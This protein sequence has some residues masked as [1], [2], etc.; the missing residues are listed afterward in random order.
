MVT[1]EAEI[2]ALDFA[3][4]D[5]ALARARAAI[6]QAQ[7]LSLGDLNPAALLG[8]LGTAIEAVGEVRLDA[9]TVNELGGQALATL[10]TLVTLPDFAGLDDVVDG[11]ER[12]AEQL[13]VP[14][15]VFSGSGDGTAVLDRVFAALSGSLDLE[16]L[17]HEITDRA[18][19][20]LEVTM[21]TEFAEPM[22]ALS[23]LA[24]EPKPAEL[25]DI[26]GTIFAGL[27][28]AAVGRLVGAAE[29]A[30]ALVV[31]AGDAGPLRAAVDAVHLRLDGAYR[32]MAAPDVDVSAL[33]AAIDDVGAA[34]DLVGSAL[35]RFAAGLGADL[36]TAANAVS[37]LDLTGSLDGIVANL[38]LPGEDIP[39][40]LVASLDGMAAHLE[41]ISGPAVTAAMAAMKDE[42]LAAA[43]LDQLADLLSG[44]DAVFAEAGAQLDRLPVRQLRDDAVAALVGCQQEVLSF[45]GFSFLDEAVAPIRDL[46]TKIRTLDTRTVTDAVNAVV[47][48]LNGLLADADVTPV[49]DAVGAVVGPLG[50]IVE[51]LVPFVK[52]VADQLGKVVDQLTG[53]DFDAA[54]TATLDLLHGIRA[55]VADAVG[56]GD[57]PEPVK[58]VVAGA[59]A[60]LR[61]MDVSA[62]LTAPFGGA[63]KLIDVGA[64]VEPIQGTWHVAGDALAKATPAALIAELDPPFQ[65]LVAAL[66]GLSLQPLIDSVQRLFD[67]AV[68]ELGRLDPRTLV[69][70]LETRFQDLVRELTAAL[71]PAPL[72]APLRAAYQALH[73]LLDEIDVA[74]T[75]HSVLGGLVD[76]PHQMSSRL[77]GRLQEGLSGAA[78]AQVAAA[79]F[80]LGDVLRPLALFLGEVRVKLARLGGNALGPVLAE[81]AA[82]TRSLRELTDTA[83]G[84]AVRLGDAV[85]TRLAWLS[86]TSG[87]GPLAQLRS[88][89]E[90]FQMAVQTLDVDAAARVRLTASAGAVQFDARVH[91]DAHVEATEQATQLRGTADSAALGRSLRL[92]GR[93]LDEAL[94]AELLTGH[95][96][97]TAATD[98]FLDAVFDRV[99]PSDLA[100]QLDAIGARIEARFV[101]LAEEL[102][103]G[104]FA[105]IAAVFNSIEPLMP[106][107]VIKRL[108]DGIDGVLARFTAL[109]P[110]PIE[111]E[112]RAV[113]HAAISLLAVHSPAALAAEL[114]H[115][116][117]ACL[118]R[119]RSLSPATL[120]AGADPFAPI[121]AQLETMKPSVILAPLVTETAEFTVALDAIASIDLT[122]AVGAVDELKQN[123]ETVLE[124]VQREWNALLDELARISGGVSV[125]VSVG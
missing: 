37:V 70:P 44:M 29:G 89:L 120:F 112:V 58:A 2:G 55:Q 117:E 31:G 61:E 110:A 11:L 23:A 41:Q 46:E 102:A 18:V 14:A 95:L 21:P 113:V 88:D 30:I 43:G 68:A 119:I 57:V 42:V 124:G 108:Q 65:D 40:E 59:A 67:D 111:E 80:R 17:L 106:N 86:P 96:D 13:A 76:M 87:A 12:L 71:D 105:L 53:I 69:A 101:A 116:F 109:D 25:L 78:P 123:F 28:I 63:V 47:D 50:D 20:A 85:D 77:G 90:S 7:Q 32:L 22:R 66:D 100:D 49:R 114:G 51:R 33:V 97:P 107:S 19:R 10:G 8:D 73:Q 56:G 27:D 34:V 3:E 24:G 26:L 38:P 52:Q 45:D 118:N 81:L 94:P 125:S 91:L 36:R 16:T 75:L 39:R 84:F 122:F 98:A 82:A 64:L 104:L 79:D 15:A 121:K 60:V 4:I 5:A 103:N 93:A 72:F 9:A 1:F 48:Q 99:D 92:L 35:P 83:T 115:V 62:K 6:E 74:A 54:G